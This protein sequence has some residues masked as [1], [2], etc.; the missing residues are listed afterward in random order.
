MTHGGVIFYGSSFQLGAILPLRG[1][2][3]W[4]ETVLVV[5]TEGRGSYWHLGRS[6]PGERFSTLHSTA[7][8]IIQALMGT[9]LLDSRTLCNHIRT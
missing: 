3:Q 1:H 4:L 5:M 9:V 8:S 2:R 7:Q 6:R